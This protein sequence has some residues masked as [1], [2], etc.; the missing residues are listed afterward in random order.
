MA[1]QTMLRACEDAVLS[2]L[3]SRNAGNGVGEQ[4]TQLTHAI[5]QQPTNTASPYVGLL[6]P[7]QRLPQVA[8][9][10]PGAHTADTRKAVTAAH[11]CVA[12][13]H[14]RHTCMSLH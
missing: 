14:C 10:Y 6:G 7:P 11:T 4:Q 3:V 5:I 2:M 9:P 1:V 8:P 13:V 12:L